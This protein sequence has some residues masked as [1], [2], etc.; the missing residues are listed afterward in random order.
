MDSPP[1]VV[2]GN[3]ITVVLPDGTAEARTVS[4]V[5]GNNITVSAAF[6]QLPAPHSA[7]VVESEDL[8]AQR[9]RV[10]SVT[11]KTDGIGYDIT[12]LQ[13]VEGKFDFVEQGTK[14]DE[15]PITPRP[16]RVQLPPS[17]L[18]ISHREFA[19]E[20]VATTIVTMSWVAPAG[21][22]SYGVEWRIADG[23]WNKLPDSSETTAEVAGITPGEFT[24]KVTASNSAGVKSAPAVL[25][26][27]VVPDQTTTPGVIDDLTDNIAQEIID[28]LA[29][30]AANA[31][32]IID[33]ATARASLAVEVAVVRAQVG[34][35]LEADE[36]VQANEYP[37][38]DL[39]QHDGKLYR[40]L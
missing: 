36:W 14:I 17:N 22:V 4:V 38:G 8:A 7:W 21:A 35:I 6:S 18:A 24:F 10:L 29:A 28:R 25:A 1:Q 20:V 39:V 37:L 40:A 2:P 5:S 30:D 11:E 12:A 15:P 33:E 34:D 19:G 32:A 31:Q 27:Y 3:K 23:A 16:S 26:G 9:F 13:H